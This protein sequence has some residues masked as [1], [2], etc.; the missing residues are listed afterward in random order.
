MIYD[1][2]LTDKI[3]GCAIQVHKSLGS[4]YLEKLY[5]RALMIELADQGLKAESQVPMQV[6]YKN[7]I[8]GDHLLDIIVEDRVILELKACAKI[9]PAHEAQLI[10]YLHAAKKK[11]GYVINFGSVGRLEFVRKVL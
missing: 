1:K 5:E 10:Q 7:Q 3:I 2:E 4:S 9:H 11:V 8:I 6:K